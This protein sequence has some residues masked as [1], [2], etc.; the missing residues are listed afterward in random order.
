MFSSLQ[1]GV[2]I[3]LN[4]HLPH[5]RNKSCSLYDRAQLFVLQELVGTGRN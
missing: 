2:V 1:L 3:A 4:V 5:K